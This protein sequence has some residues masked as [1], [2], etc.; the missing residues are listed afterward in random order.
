MGGDQD[1][2]SPSVVGGLSRLWVWFQRSSVLGTEQGRGDSRVGDPDCPQPMETQED[3]KDEH[4]QEEQ[5]LHSE[6]TWAAKP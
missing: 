1:R 6:K 5:K 3:L 2:M 4:K